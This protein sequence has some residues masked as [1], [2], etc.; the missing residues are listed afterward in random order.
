[1]LHHADNEATND[2]NEK[3]QQPGNR[4]ASNKLTGAIHRA[5]KIRLP[6]HISPAL[7]CFIL[8][9]HPGIHIRINRHLL[10]RHR[11]QGK[12]CRDFRDPARTFGHN[13]KVDNH[14]DTENHQANGIVSAND[15]IAKG[16]NDFAR[17]I[18][19][20]MTIEQNH[21]SRGKVKRQTQQRRNK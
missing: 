4:I 10:A 2:I 15:K 19:P 16:L 9:E 13:N 18:R 21:P 7:P 5:I 6:S 14:Q 20:C 17:S 12:P 1:M 11:V 8:G 3:D